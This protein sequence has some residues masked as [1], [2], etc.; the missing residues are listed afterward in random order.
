MYIWKNI[1]YIIK[2]HLETRLLQRMFISCG[3]DSKYLITTTLLLNYK[4]PLLMALKTSQYNY[5]F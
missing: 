1:M 4:Y 3:L 2:A 5:S